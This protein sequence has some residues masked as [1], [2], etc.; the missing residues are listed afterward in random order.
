MSQ[1]QSIYIFNHPEMGITMRTNDALAAAVFYDDLLGMED[2][3]DSEEG[4][5]IQ[6]IVAQKVAS[7]MAKSNKKVKGKVKKAPAITLTPACYDAALKRVEEVKHDPVCGQLFSI[8]DSLYSTS[9]AVSVR[10]LM[11]E[12]GVTG[13]KPQYLAC[14]SQKVGFIF[15]DVPKSNKGR[16][17]ISTLIHK[18]NGEHGM[19]W[20]STPELITFIDYYRKKQSPPIHPTNIRDVVTN[21]A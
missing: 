3:V 16:D 7:G 13:K 5:T 14:I 17:V 20:C 9:G 1:D 8:M 18:R 21:N 19:E 11:K 2:R 15:Q 6:Q 10:E 4:P 12:A